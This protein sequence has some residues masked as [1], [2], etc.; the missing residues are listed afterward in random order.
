MGN[1]VLCSM[2]QSVLKKRRWLLFLHMTTTT[3]H[4]FLTSKSELHKILPNTEHYWI[5]VKRKAVTS[6]E[7]TS[8]PKKNSKSASKA[9]TKSAQKKMKKTI[10]IEHCKSWNVFKR[11]AAT[12]EA[13]FKDKGFA[14]EI[15]KEK[16][17]K[18]AFVVKEEGNEK[19]LIE[20]LDMPR[21]FTKLKTLDFDTVLAECIA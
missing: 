20:L 8:S 2:V 13:F 19:A 1:F 3:T 21:P 10:F 15:N 16:P 4:F 7:E 11:K 18:G 17:R 14:I 12:V 6:K 9:D 5:M